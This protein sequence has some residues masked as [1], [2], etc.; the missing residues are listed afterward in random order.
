M[1][2]AK[3]PSCK[4]CHGTPQ[5]QPATLKARHTGKE[6]RIPSL[7]H[8][9]H[10]RYGDQ[11]ECMVCHAT[12]SFNDGARYLLLSR[13]DDFDPWA[14]LIVQGSSELEHIL[15]HNLYSDEE[16]LA[17]TMEDGITGEPRS[18]LWYKGYTQRRWEDIMIRRDRD[19][20]IKIFRPILDLHLSF[21][22]EEGNVIFDNIDSTSP[23]HL[24][25]TPHTTGPAGLFYQHRFQHL[26]ESHSSEAQ[27]HE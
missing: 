22:D 17:P 15:E 4:S 1:Y 18:G 14:N 23:T 27:S 7:R 16:E 9:A 25:Y 24:P 26:L 6:H 13:D 3:G 11:V 19:G 20:V 10:K 12:W 8:P 5:D 21:V 2:K